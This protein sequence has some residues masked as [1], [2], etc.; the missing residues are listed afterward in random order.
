MDAPENTEFQKL[1]SEQTLNFKNVFDL[2]K[3]H[4]RFYEL[5]AEQLAE[6]TEVENSYPS[7]YKTTNT[8]DPFLYH[9][10]QTNTP[11]EVFYRAEPVQRTVAGPT[12]IT[13]LKKKGFK[14]RS[15]YEDTGLWTP[16]E[17][18]KI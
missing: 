12:A 5:S 17:K 10:F 14:T 16:F 3:V 4:G 11:K 13:D 8:M 6:H 18:A 7:D 15:I 9:V 2:M 1:L